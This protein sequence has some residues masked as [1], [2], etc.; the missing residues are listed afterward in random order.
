MKHIKKKKKIIIIFFIIGKVLPCRYCRE[1]YMEF[2]NELDLVNNLKSQENKLLNGYMICIIKVNRKL[3]VPECNIPY[4]KE[5]EERY[6]QFRA[7]CKNYRRRKRC[8][9]KKVV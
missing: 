9:S 7:K 3:G 1:S 8:Q 5:L 2:F 6:E 4:I